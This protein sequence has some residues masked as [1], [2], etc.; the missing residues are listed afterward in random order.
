MT[1]PMSYGA[2]LSPGDHLGVGVPPECHDD[3]MEPRPRDGD[4]QPYRCSECR[5]VL[6]VNTTTGLVFDIR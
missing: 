4:L 5:T 3:E 6:T 2:E 1:F